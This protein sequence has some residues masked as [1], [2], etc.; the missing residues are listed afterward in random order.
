M[1]PQCPFQ[2]QQRRIKEEFAFHS[3][4]P[5]VTKNSRQG[6]SSWGLEVGLHQQHSMW[7]SQWLR[8]S[9]LSLFLYSLWIY[10]LWE[11][12]TFLLSLSVSVP[13]GATFLSET[14]DLVVDERSGVV[15]LECGLRKK[16]GKNIGLWGEWSM[17]DFT[18]VYW[19]Q[20]LLLPDSQ[21]TVFTFLEGWGS[22]VTC[23][24]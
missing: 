14:L 24:G 15:F 6:I 12:T 20:S 3:V 21:R 5:G 13:R 7:S 2:K 1:F 17:D 22:P 4:G 10:S 9:E 23:F 16:K 19:Y 18:T 8:V 11:K